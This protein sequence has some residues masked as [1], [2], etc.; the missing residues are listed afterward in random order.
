MSKGI[1]KTRID[2][3]RSKKTHSGETVW[4]K[5]K[6]DVILIPSGYSSPRDTHPLRRVA[7]NCKNRRACVP[8]LIPPGAL[9]PIRSPTVW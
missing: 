3:V 2:R 8:V 4:W 1:Y 5:I 6:E 9:M 7:P